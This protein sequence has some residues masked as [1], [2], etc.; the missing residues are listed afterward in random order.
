MS[1]RR[2]KG[3]SKDSDGDITEL[4]NDSVWGRVSKSSAIS[5]IENGTHSYYT[6]EE[7]FKSHIH[8][9]QKADG[10][11]Y[12]RSTADSNSKNNLDNLP[13]C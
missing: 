7:S 11:K 1:D 6:W 8:V 12:L 10:S 13:D 4:C 5:H 2:V 9:V 3:S